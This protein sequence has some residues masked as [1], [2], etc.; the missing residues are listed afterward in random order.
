MPET[1]DIDR[2]RLNK[3]AGWISIFEAP[4]VAVSGL[5]D[6]FLPSPASAI[7]A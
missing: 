3:A 1:P 4:P 6:D 5:D 2:K 7:R